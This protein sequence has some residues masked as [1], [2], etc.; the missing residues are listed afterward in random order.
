M[1]ARR[2]GDRRERRR[3]RPEI[4]VDQ[5]LD[6]LAEHGYRDLEVEQTAVENVVFGLP[7]SLAGNP[8]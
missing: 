5:L 2:V 6:R 4:L 7:S 3:E 1:A 8:A